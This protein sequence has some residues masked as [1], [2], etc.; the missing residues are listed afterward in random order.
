MSKCGKC[1]VIDSNKISMPIEVRASLTAHDYPRLF[2]L[3]KRS[4][5]EN[6]RGFKLVLDHCLW[7]FAGP[8]RPSCTQFSGRFYRAFGA[9]KG[10]T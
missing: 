5:P 4:T 9:V 8:R 2:T 6:P 7:S 1:L 10:E 3:L